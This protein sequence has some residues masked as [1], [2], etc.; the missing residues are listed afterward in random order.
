VKALPWHSKL[1]SARPVYHDETTCE[2]GN[3]I[4]RENVAPGTDGRRKCDRCR[5]ISG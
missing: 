1:P 5:E 2:I 3:N 4:E